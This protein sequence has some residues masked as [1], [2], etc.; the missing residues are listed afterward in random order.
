M[1]LPTIKL[2]LSDAVRLYRGKTKELVQTQGSPFRR[3]LLIDTV[4]ALW[5][6]SDK[7]VEMNEEM[8]TGHI[9]NTCQSLADEIKSLKETLPNLVKNT[10]ESNFANGSKEGN[11]QGSLNIVKHS[12]LIEQQSEEVFNKSAWNDVVKR[13]I[14]LKLK[15]VPVK[16]SSLTKAG[17]GCLIF[18]TKEDQEKAELVLKNDFK[19]TKSTKEPSKLLPKLKVCNLDS[20]L[21]N[22]KD[23]LKEAILLKNH[24]V[25]NLVENGGTLDVIIIDDKSKYAV[26]KVSP[27]VRNEIMKQGKVFIDMQSHFV[28]DN[29]HITQCFSCQQFGHKQGSDFC[30]NKSGGSNCLYCGGT[31]RSKDCMQ[32]HEKS[33]HKCINCEQSKNN[34]IRNAAHGHTSTS[35]ECPIF[36]KE[37]QLLI[38]KTVGF[39]EG[40]N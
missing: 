24:G 39:E 23:E 16:K 10:I 15:S 30:K 6:I 28:K 2:K 9:V 34:Q 5:D 14:A 12:V 36:K 7:L 20:Y 35:K 4:F 27:Q 29:W 22:E 26:L 11:S 8:Q 38:S 31:H 18:P 32:K 17:Q 21:R 3:E 19:V 40:K 25:K 33:A 1:D 37:V 13:D